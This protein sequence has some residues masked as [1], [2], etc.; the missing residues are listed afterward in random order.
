V[1]GSASQD[2]TFFAGLPREELD[3]V[4][5]AAAE[6]DFAAGQ[7]LV[8]EG[9]LGHCLFVI[10]SGAAI[11]TSGGENRGEV[12]PGDVVGEIAVLSSGRRTTTV[13]ATTPVRALAWFKRDVWE[14]ERTAPEAAR[15]L[16]A[17]LDG[18]R[19]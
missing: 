2:I 1:D 13:V 15:R 10:V 12:G 18:H 6:V 11:V 19:A 5:R 9:D 17:A 8:A 3:E 7:E 14:L 16:R 4:S